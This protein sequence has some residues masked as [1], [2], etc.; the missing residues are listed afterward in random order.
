MRSHA[1]AHDE[2]TS[3]PFAGHAPEQERP[4]GAYGALLG[5]FLALAGAFAAFFDASGRE[6]PDT[7][8]PG[9]LALITVAGHKAAR[10]IARDRVTSVVRAPF[11]RFQRDAGPAEVDEAARGRG[12]RR[13]IG[14]LLVCPYCL[15]MWVSATL[16]ASLLV[17]PRFTRWTCAVLVAFFGSELL[18]L[19][20]ARAQR[21]V[22]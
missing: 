6:L 18:Q 1:L 8:A 4:L 10:L 7:I 5:T 12:L 17:L 11:T 15:G 20:Y 19:A 13:A 2:S 9:D 3:N 22:G 21:W 16:T 14:E